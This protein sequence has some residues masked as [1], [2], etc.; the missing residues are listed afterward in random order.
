MANMYTSPNAQT[1]PGQQVDMS[2]TTMRN[3]SSGQIAPMVANQEQQLAGLQSPQMRQQ[4]IASSDIPAQQANYDDLARQ[5]YEYDKS[6][7]SSNFNANPQVAP[8]A[9]SSSRVAASPYDLTA[10]S[11][12]GNTFQF[13]NP[14]Y[15]VSSQTAQKGTVVDLLNNLN[16]AI[17]KELTAKRG[18]YS[19]SVQSSKT[20]LAGLM[21]M[22][23]RAE[24]RED[25]E[26]ERA[27]RAAE[28]AQSRVDRANSELDSAI[29]SGISQLQNGEPW[30]VV[31]NRIKARFPLA[32]DEEIDSRLGTEWKQAGAYE[33]FKGR[34]SEAKQSLSAE[35]MKLQGNVK[36]ALTDIQKVRDMISKD[37]G[38]LIKAEAQIASGG[39]I[40]GLA[41]DYYTAAYN[42]M[43]VISRLRTGAAINPEE[44]SFYS[45]FIPRWGDDEQTIKNKLDRLEAYYNSFVS[46]REVMGTAPD[47]YNGTSSGSEW[48]VVQ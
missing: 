4:T 19:S 48:E 5:L 46:G 30:G 40:P 18:A 33:A 36:S 17:S 10:S 31:W 24:N 28:R 21:D 23:D 47:Q 8:D 11:L 35:R 42:I 41:K 39:K 13:G 12:G 38:L 22:L 3:M 27:E 6:I 9:V 44:I 1:I 20:I 7:T 45:Q 14:E 32:K 29:A 26:A 34:Q 25:R 2:N 16:T 37:D 15:A 43:D